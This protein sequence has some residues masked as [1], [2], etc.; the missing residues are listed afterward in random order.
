MFTQPHVGPRVHAQCPTALRALSQRVPVEGPQANVVA[1]LPWE[2]PN[3]EGR[4][5][6][7]GI[8]TPQDH[9]KWV[10]NLC[11]SVP[12]SG[13]SIISVASIVSNQGCYDDQMVGRA[14]AILNTGIGGSSRTW[15]HHWALGTEVTQYDVDLFALAKATQWATEFYANQEPP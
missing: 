12:T 14:A 7:M 11:R 15:N 4:T 2:V 13:V 5:N 1:I 9:K 8:T 6:H 10:N 3:W